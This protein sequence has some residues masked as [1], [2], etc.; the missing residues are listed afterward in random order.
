MGLWKVFGLAAAGMLLA[1]GPSHAAAPSLETEAHNSNDFISFDI[2]PFDIGV[3]VA[4]NAASEITG[5][6]LDENN[7]F[8][9]FVRGRDGSVVTFDAPAAVCS[10]DL[11]CTFP[12]AINSAG[13][14][15]GFY[16]AAGTYHGFLRA[17]GGQFTSFDP[18][19]ST[20]TTPYAMNHAGDLAGNYDD[21]NHVGHGFIRT[22]AG[23]FVT[24]DIVGS[25][26]NGAI[27]TGLN[28]AGAVTGSFRDAM[29]GADHGFVRD[30]DGEITIFDPAGSTGTD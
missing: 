9:G 25:D 15:A 19:G 30:S 8:H 3:P 11:I 7:S 4:I 24:F 1:A 10:P 20:Q 2:G 18:P 17:R 14:I 21:A 29:T 22:K 12:D 23:A 28:S 13:T 6:Y 27:A 16:N 26:D 5:Y